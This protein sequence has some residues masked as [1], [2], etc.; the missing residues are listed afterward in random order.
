MP[1][2]SF[3]STSLRILSA[4]ASILLSAT[5]KDIAAKP[6]MLDCENCPQ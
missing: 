1:L 4:M 6:M 5:Y 2:L 3:I